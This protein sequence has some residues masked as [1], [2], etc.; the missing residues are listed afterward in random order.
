VACVLLAAGGSRRL[1]TPKQLVR[2][3]TRSLLAHALAAA[4]AA[5]PASPIIVVLGAEALRLRPVVT[6]AACHARV[7][8]NP[9]WAEGLATSLQAGL[10]AVPATAPAALIVL[11]DQPDVGERALRRLVSAWR[12]RAG[13]P[14]AAYYGGHTGV[15]AILPRRFWPDLRELEGD[16]GARALLR[17]AAVVTRVAMPEA[18]LDIDTPADVARLRQTTELAHAP[19]DRCA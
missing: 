2:R 6:R 10:A 15:P 14:A 8:T 9:R 19:E 7:V 13:Q 18:V 1:G 5:L 12:R 11:V 4:R 3:G 16:S 17:G